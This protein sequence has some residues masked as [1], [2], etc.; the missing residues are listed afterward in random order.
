MEEIIVT[1]TDTIPGKKIVDLKNKTLMAQLL[2]SN[3]EQRGLIPPFLLPFF[4]LLE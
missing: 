4:W 2:L 3:K 1:T